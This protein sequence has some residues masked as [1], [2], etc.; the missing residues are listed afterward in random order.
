MV[1]EKGRLINQRYRIIEQ[2]GVGGMAIVYKATDEKLDRDVTFKVLKESYIDDEDFIIRFSTEARAAARLSHSNIVNVYDVGNEGNIYYIVMEYI[3]GFTLKDLIC[4]KAPFS[5][6]EA[7]GIAIQIGLGL[8]NAHSHDIVHRDIKPENILI[9]N[10]G[11]EGSVKVTDFGIAQ[12]LTA[13][14]T[15]T[16]YMGSVHYFS[17]EQAKG[18]KADAR[19]DIYSLG[20]VLFEMVTGRQPFEGDTP[21]ALAMQHLKEPVPDIKKINPQVSNAIVA[22]I[23]KCLSKE[24]RNRYQSADALVKDLRRAIGLKQNTIDTKDVAPAQE[25]AKSTTIMY[26]G[27]S[28]IN[29][30]DKY[31][32]DYDDEDY[33]DEYNK[34]REKKI[35]MSAIIAGVVLL[36]L[37]GISGYFLNESLNGNTVRVPDFVGLSASEAAA[38]AESR[39]LTVEFE[40]VFKEGAEAGEVVE[41]SI[42]EGKRVD[43]GTAVELSI[44]VGGDAVP[45][46]DIKG[47]TRS[48]AEDKLAEAGLSI[49]DTTYV[50]SDEPSGT[51]LSQDPD[52]GELV[53]INSFIN[54]EVSQGNIDEEVEMPDLVDKT[55][56]EAEEL[57]DELG[58]VPKFID[59]FSD[60]IEEGK[61]IDQGVKEG[62]LISVGSSVTLT[63]SKGHGEVSVSTTE[64][65][66]EKPPVEDITEAT[67][68][69]TNPTSSINDDTVVKKNVNLYISP[70]FNSNDFGVTDGSDVYRVLVIA[71]NSQGQKEV[72]N[73]RYAI[74]DFP[75]TF[76]DTITESTNYQVYINDTLIIDKTE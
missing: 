32:N 17:P 65:E 19:S 71:K 16:D 39:G 53:A 76:T 42:E 30:K 72:L 48:R 56:E 61:I 64:A 59:G 75:F 9:T 40:Q 74:S 36:L 50:H 23:K 1:L 55:K 2:I 57:L 44:N 66:T 21:I 49:G 70:D 27:H 14:T 43:R 46:P 69:N 13:P 10:I 52:A 6:V 68:A 12:A 22:I 5:D 45:V 24:P 37:I 18:E 62:T 11:G 26:D 3:D 54:I 73:D 34:K 20:V 29:T 8:A 58:L 33:D 7:A 63:L 35:V 31:E 4:S 51:V 15:P 38:K 28:K 41:Q 60:T 47:I 67:S 25:E